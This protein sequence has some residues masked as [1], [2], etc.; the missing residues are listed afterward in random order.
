MFWLAQLYLRL[1][2]LL[3]C[4]IVINLFFSL[5]GQSVCFFVCVDP[6]G[7]LSEIALLCLSWEWSAYAPASGPWANFIKR[8]ASFLKISSCD[9]LFLSFSFNLSR[10]LTH[11]AALNA[12]NYLSL[13]LCV[14]R[15]DPNRHF[16]LKSANTHSLVVLNAV[17][18]RRG[19]RRLPKFRLAEFN[20][21]DMFFV[22]IADRLWRAPLRPPEHKHTQAD[23]DAGP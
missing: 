10:S 17:V 19:T 18:I 3:N 6:S 14:P 12:S 1:V 7:S 8:A 4:K 22:L 20:L 23:L 5:L 21:G 2:T 16:D 13:S 9:R 11:S 15:P